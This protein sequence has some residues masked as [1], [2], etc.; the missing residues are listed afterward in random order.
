MRR[1]HLFGQQPD[2]SPG[3]RSERNDSFSRTLR[4]ALVLCGGIALGWLGAA[5]YA[6]GHRNLDLQLI[7]QAWNIIQRHYVDQSAIKAR[8]VSYGAVAGM[9][10]ALGDT[11]HSTFLSPDMVKALKNM[12]HG[13]FKG[14]G[15]E[16]RM[17]EGHVVVVAPIDGSPA[18]RAGL[19]T[20]DIILKVNGE[21]ITGWPISRAVDRITGPI[22]TK[23]D[24][25]I[26]NPKTGRTRAVTITRTSVKLH[27]VTW[28]EL[29]GTKIAHVRIADF[30]GGVVKDF[31][32]ALLAIRD[33]GMDAI[34]LDLRNN[35]G[36]IFDAAV[37]VASQFLSSGNVLLVKDAHGNIK[38]I[39]AEKGGLATNL[40]IAVLI[41]QGTASASEII[42]G[43][44]RDGNRAT[45][46][47]ETTFGTGTV[48]NEFK[49]YDSSALLLAIQ[50]WLTPNGQSFWHKGISPEVA[51]A[52]PDDVAPLLPEAEHG[53][54]QEQ[55]ESSKD[56][57][58]L[59]AV[60]ILRKPAKQEAVELEHTR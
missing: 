27:A 19:R 50:E 30:T 33:Q 55:L 40:P 18:Q 54:T 22:G 60:E 21:G 26:L 47:G 23:V 8:P 41:N 36:G 6:P 57:Q 59:R 42:A 13:E 39:P 37:T 12:Q 2:K 11:G 4:L 58:L 14:I 52:L 7:Q 9:V 48:L 51:V 29:P 35:P 25:M 32:K 20:G 44:L 53:M 5:G 17:K 1:T 46:I 10:D 15:V 24:L 3:E 38:P 16:I 28:V 56:T 43:A 31:K 34:I 49:L 45:L